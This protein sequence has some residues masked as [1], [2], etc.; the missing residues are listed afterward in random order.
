MLSGFAVP[1][2]FILTGYFVLVKERAIRRKKLK[3]AV[4]RSFVTFQIMFVVYIAINAVIFAANNAD[5][6]SEALNTRALFNFLVLNVWPFPIGSNIWFIQ[7]LLYAYVFL[8]LADRRR[9]GMRHHKALMVLCMI[10]MVASGELAGLLNFN[11]LGY[12]Y[13]PGG[14]VTRA[15]P[16]V[17][18]GMCL[19]EKADRLKAVRGWV[20]LLIFMLGAMLALG[21]IVWL[22]RIG[23]LVYDSHMLGCGVMAAAACA[24]AVSRPEMKRTVFSSHGRKYAKRIYALANPVY[25]AL[26]LL[27]DRLFPQ[28]FELTEKFAG[29]VVY[30]ICLLICVL[31]TAVKKRV[32]DKMRKFKWGGAK[33][34]NAGT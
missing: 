10:F 13:I 15:L 34:S 28:H 33:R 16:Y 14:A 27:A 23:K 20:Y 5:W 2:Y 22:D 12:T 6:A 30:L 17:L 3:R 29:I 26:L 21:E 4:Q 19:R 1:A 25:F 31:I 11:I 24:W 18:L 8:L 9:G 32:T 7:A